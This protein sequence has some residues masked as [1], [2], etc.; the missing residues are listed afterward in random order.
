MLAR[1]LH[2]HVVQSLL[3]SLLCSE[4]H[5]EGAHLTFALLSVAV[6][7]SKLMNLVRDIGVEL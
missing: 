1:F 3:S 7:V 6:L 5:M 2:F 4:E